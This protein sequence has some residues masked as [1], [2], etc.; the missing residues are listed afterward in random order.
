MHSSL[1][2]YS[3]RRHA[4]TAP[5]NSNLG[6]DTCLMDASLDFPTTNKHEIFPAS[7]VNRLYAHAP[8]PACDPSLKI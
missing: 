7:S 6:M 5:D 4:T 1:D 8:Y 3:Y 2:N